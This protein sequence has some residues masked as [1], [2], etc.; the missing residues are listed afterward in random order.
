MSDQTHTVHALA[1]QLIATMPKTFAPDI[2]IVLLSIRPVDDVVV[3][4]NFRVAEKGLGV[5]DDENETA[6]FA[7]MQLTPAMFVG[8][9][10]PVVEVVQEMCAISATHDLISL[11]LEGLRKSTEVHIAYGGIKGVFYVSGN[12]PLGIK[13]DDQRKGLSI[14]QVV[15][16]GDPRE[17]CFASDSG[18]LISRS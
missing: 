11:A 4:L 8:S 5:T 1:E 17:L 7:T 15:G 16:G 2:E 3:E 6:F 12:G 9:D 13:Y 10:R 14:D 18:G